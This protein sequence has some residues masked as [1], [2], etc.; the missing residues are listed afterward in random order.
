VLCSALVREV[1][2]EISLVSLSSET[3]VQLIVEELASAGASMIRMPSAT[4]I[5][6][7]QRPGR[8]R[9][10]RLYVA[11]TAFKKA[12]TSTRCED[13]A[14]AWGGGGGGGAI[15]LSDRQSV[16]LGKLSV[17]QSQELSLD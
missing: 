11:L 2:K 7:R 9:K 10:P 4:A 6:I 17:P 1:G 16:A 5:E 13:T 12:I 14:E 8:G 15:Y 3:E